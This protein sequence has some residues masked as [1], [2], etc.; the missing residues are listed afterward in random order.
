[1]SLL[2]F[3]LGSLLVVSGCGGRESVSGTVRREGEPL[4]TGKVI[5]SPVSG[6]KLAFGAIQPDGTFQLTTESADDGAV[7][8]QYRVMIASGGSA[9][10]GD[11]RVTY[12][13][14]PQRAFQI[15]AGESN[16]FEID[17]RVADGWEAVEN[18]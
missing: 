14:P 18:K 10:G 12:L 6:G 11:Q 4:A 16:Q 8:G 2:P 3:V 9:K 5:F 13:S 17:V 7:A 15:N 1:M